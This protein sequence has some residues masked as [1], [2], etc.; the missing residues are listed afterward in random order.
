M[1]TVTPIHVASWLR[2]AGMS[3]SGWVDVTAI[4]LATGPDPSKPGGVWGIGGPAGDGPAQAREAASRYASKGVDGFPA[5]KSGGY[6]LM[7]PLAAATTAG[8]SATEPVGDV[9]QGAITAGQTAADAAA[10]LA[11][12]GLRINRAI[13]DPVQWQAIAYTMAGATLIALGVVGI[14]YGVVVRPGISAGGQALN[15]IDVAA[16][17]LA[18]RKH[19]FSQAKSLAKSIGRSRS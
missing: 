15:R 13:A 3:G 16:F 11:E 9:A 18:W 6:R 1:A 7:L 4:G 17:N 19:F 2:D 5:G 10:Q 8:V 12:L 14:L